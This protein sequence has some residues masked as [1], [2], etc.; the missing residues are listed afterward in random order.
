MKGGDAFADDH[1]SLPVYCVLHVQLPGQS[2]AS[3]YQTKRRQVPVPQ[4]A[5]LRARV[6]L[7]APPTPSP[8]MMLLS[9]PAW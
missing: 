7:I 9:L 4:A 5:Q 8:A 1:T 6:L 3:C 2:C